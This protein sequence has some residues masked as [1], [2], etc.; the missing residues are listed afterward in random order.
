MGGS[1]QGQR[2]WLFC[3][4]ELWARVL[5]CKLELLPV[6]WVASCVTRAVPSTLWWSPTMPW[7]KY[8]FLP[9][10]QWPFSLPLASFCSAPEGCL[11]LGVPRLVA[12][13]L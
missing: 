3:D 12:G 1:P 8:L 6:M 2:A 9:E 10:T 4:L 11:L 5:T 13:C 7:R